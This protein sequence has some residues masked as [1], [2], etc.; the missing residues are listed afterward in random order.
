[1][2]VILAVL[3]LVQET[4][5]DVV[6]SVQVVVILAALE[7]VQETVLDAETVQDN[8]MECVLQHVM[9]IA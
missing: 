1:M 5:L 3:E 4:V 2:V 7:L 9:V 8:V 6:H